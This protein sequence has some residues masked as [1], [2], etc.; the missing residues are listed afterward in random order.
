MKLKMNGFFLTIT[1]AEF[2]NFIYIVLTVLTGTITGRG[3]GEIFWPS[4]LKKSR[5]ARPFQ[6]LVICGLSVGL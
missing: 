2:C 4:S 1:D 6:L 5:L 3:R